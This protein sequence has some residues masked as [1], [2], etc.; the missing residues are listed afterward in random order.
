[1]PRGPRLDA[2]GLLQHVIVR[3]IEQR[4]I[5]LSDADRQDGVR[6]LARLVPETQTACLAWCFLSNHLRLLVRSGPRGVAHF[7]RRFLTGY[8]EQTQSHPRNIDESWLAVE[9]P[10]APSAAGRRDPFDP[11]IL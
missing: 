1:M 8:V 3:G 6:R 9:G 2:P 11:R 4:P 7:M 5:F 10:D